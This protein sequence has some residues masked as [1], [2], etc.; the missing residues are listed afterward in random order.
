MRLFWQGSRQSQ[1]NDVVWCRG[2]CATHSFK[3]WG[4]R[5]AYGDAKEPRTPAGPMAS[6][7][8]APL[9]ELSGEGDEVL[10]QNPLSIDDLHP[11]PEF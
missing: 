2:G 9:G 5:R 1:W 3:S 11:L 8:L 7:K 6:G 4:L 10:V